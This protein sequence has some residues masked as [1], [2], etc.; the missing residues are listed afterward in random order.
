MSLAIATPEH[1]IRA[2][3]LRG[4]VWQLGSCHDYEVGIDGPAGTGKTFGILYYIHLLLLKYQG[5][6]ALVT[7]RYNTDL[8]GSAANQDIS[9]SGH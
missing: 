3:E 4:A 1:I 7:R 5:A 2:P 8:A 9:T 6:K